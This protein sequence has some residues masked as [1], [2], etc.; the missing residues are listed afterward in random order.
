M[1]QALARERLNTTRG[2]EQAPGLCSAGAL[3]TAAGAFLLIVPFFFMAGLPAIA[4]AAMISLVAHF[5]VG[6]AESLITIR[7]WWSNGLEM[8]LVGAAEGIV[9]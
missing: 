3:L 8:T 1:I 6:A 4:A 2:T 9:T 5:A 7:S